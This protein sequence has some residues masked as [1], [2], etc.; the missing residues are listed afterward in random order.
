MLGMGA[1]EGGYCA[2]PPVSEAVLPGNRCLAPASLDHDRR[3]G[4]G[5][6]LDL[7]RLRKSSRFFAVGY[8]TRLKNGEVP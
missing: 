2:G 6:F 7:A 5:T 1:E 8:F 3:D 4:V